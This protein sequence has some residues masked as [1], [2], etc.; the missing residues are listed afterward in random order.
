MSTPDHIPPDHA[1]VDEPSEEISIRPAYSLTT[2]HGDVPSP[3]VGWVSRDDLI[4]EWVGAQLIGAAPAE[5]CRLELAAVIA[6]DAVDI[7]FTVAVQDRSAP[8]IEL[9][10]GVD[11]ALVD[12]RA[13]MYQRGRGTWLSARITIAPPGEYSASFNF[14]L[15]PDYGP[16]FTDIAII[17]DLDAFPRDRAH[18][19]EWLQMK[20]DDHQQSI[21]DRYEAQRR[22]Q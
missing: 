18:V 15:E 8:N 14:D 12:L 13:E 2:N 22:V 6:A 16:E 1:Q 19:P 11:R 4:T 17:K 10:P 5:W 9:P 3:A 20:I 21:Y 7:R